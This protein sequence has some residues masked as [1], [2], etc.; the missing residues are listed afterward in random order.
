MKNKIIIGMLGLALSTGLFPGVGQTTA[1][2][3][4]DVSFQVFYDQLSPY[5]NW[6]NY[7]D[8]GYVWVPEAGSGFRP[9]GTNG[10]W[11]YSDEGWTW[12][13]RYEWGWAPFH[14]GNW[15]YRSEE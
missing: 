2:A 7:P 10:H 3:Q 9:Y 13:S 5:G 8:Y 1:N 11:V 6:V 4:V 14:Y 12:V 15:F